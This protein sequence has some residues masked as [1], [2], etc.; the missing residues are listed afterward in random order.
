MTPRKPPIQIAEEMDIDTA[1]RLARIEEQLKTLPELKQL[2]ENYLKRSE[3][4]DDELEVSIN[5]RA[6]YCAAQMP[7][8]DVVI[9]DVVAF[10]ERL[11]AVEKLAPA[12]RAMIWVG[13]ALGASVIA[14]I[15]SLITGQAQLI[16][17]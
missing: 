15:W 14:L 3:K 12:I 5:N 9:K 17:R 2:L 6:L 7:R 8:V 1:E 16:F 4:K 10:D 11:K 13:A